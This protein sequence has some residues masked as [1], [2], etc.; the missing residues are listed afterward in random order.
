M[1]GHARIITICTKRTDIASCHML[2]INP[3]R[4][5][6]TEKR[7]LTTSIDTP[8]VLR[9]ESVGRRLDRHTFVTVLDGDIMHII[10]VA[11]YI[12]SIRRPD[13]VRNDLGPKSKKV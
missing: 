12:K 7:T 4:H 3:L 8:D 11:R 2:P 5:D 13:M 9:D 6:R 10:V 1:I